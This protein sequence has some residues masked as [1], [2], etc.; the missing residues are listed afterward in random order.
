MSK[1]LS[2]SPN[3]HETQFTLQPVSVVREVLRNRPE[4]VPETGSQRG[5]SLVWKEEGVLELEDRGVEEDVSTL[6][7]ES[8]RLG[9][10]KDFL[11]PWN[12]MFTFPIWTLTT[13]PQKAGKHE[14][15]RIPHAVFQ[16]PCETRTMAMK[17]QPE[18]A[19]CLL[20]SNSSQQQS[21]GQT[22]AG[23]QIP[24]VV[25]TKLRLTSLP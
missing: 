3:L 11:L 14:K 25:T 13:G 20:R 19:K 18:R 16:Q 21:Q 2:L 15:T 5:C 9:Q 6:W 1:F 17:K 7:E 8:E 23:L 4:S 12:G 24:R 10:E 22:S